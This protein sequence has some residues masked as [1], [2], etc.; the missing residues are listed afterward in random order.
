MHES[1]RRE[2]VG[3]A[4][5]SLLAANSSTSHAANQS[6]TKFPSGAILRMSRG[7]FDPARFA[8]VNAMITKTGEYLVPAIKKLPGLLAYYAATTPDGVTTQ[9]SIWESA[10]AGMQMSTL[11]EMRD[12][13]RAE[14]EALGV[15]FDPILQFPLNWT[16]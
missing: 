10:N 6:K 9:V 11:P 4:A 5:L 14:A 7:R 15:A 12:R 3:M 2:L 16:I 13:A 1:S 8:E